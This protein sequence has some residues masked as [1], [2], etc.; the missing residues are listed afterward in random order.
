MS[1]YL[2]QLQEG[3]LEQVIH[4]FGYLKIYKNTRLMFDCRYP[5]ISS[6][7]FKE[8][9]WFDF[10]RDTKEATF[11]SIPEARGQKVSV[12]IFVVADLLGE[13]FTRN[14]QKGLLICINKSPIHWYNNS[15]TTEEA[16]TF[17]VESCVMK[18][19][20]EIFEALQYKLRMCGLPTDGSAN[21][22]CDN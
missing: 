9:E 20:V 4:I 6:K 3:H 2:A 13:N 10:Y 17:G 18:S 8:Y 16:T 12:Y 1:N 22:F 7:I 5:R 11:P 14:R 19:S 21:V 15:P